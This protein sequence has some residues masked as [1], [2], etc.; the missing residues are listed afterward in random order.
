[1]PV[2]N[3]PGVSCWQEAVNGRDFTVGALDQSEWR[4]CSLLLLGGLEAAGAPHH[5]GR[6]RGP[7]AAGPTGG[8]HQSDASQHQAAAGREMAAAIN[9]APA[10]AAEVPSPL[11]AGLRDHESLCWNLIRSVLHTHVLVSG[12][13]KSRSTDQIVASPKMSA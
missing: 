4:C 3:A 8:R 7:G 1:M 2:S 6:G 10:A 5:G 13:D 9:S 11:E 12:H